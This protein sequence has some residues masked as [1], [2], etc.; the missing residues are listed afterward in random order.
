[1]LKKLLLTTLVLTSMQPMLAMRIMSSAEVETWADEADAGDIVGRTLDKGLI[2]L[3]KSPVKNVELRLQNIQRLLD[4]GASPDAYDNHSKKDALEWALDFKKNDIAKFLILRQAKLTGNH[5]SAVARMGNLELCKLMIT[6]ANVNFRDECGWTPLYSATSRGHCSIM[7]F[8]I[9][10]G[11]D[12]NAKTNE[13]DTPL[14]QVS[15]LAAQRGKS[16]SELENI[17]RLLIAHGADKNI[18]NL[19]GETAYD[20]YPKFEF[21]KPDTEGE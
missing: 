21:L 8:L 7:K 19:D 16:T 15:Y 2:D 20:R 9:E 3:I 13:Q 17:C 12:V 6:S 11:A 18:K 14:L 10:N 4:A 1:M 5:L